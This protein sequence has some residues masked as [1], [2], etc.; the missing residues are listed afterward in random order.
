M[1]NLLFEIGLEEL[2]A[3]FI[4]DA[5][6]DLKIQLHQRLDQARLLN[7]NS[8]IT[9][10]GTARRLAVIATNIKKAQ[11]SIEESLEGPP[12]KIAKSDTGDWL[13][14]AIG[15]AKKCDV[16]ISQLTTRQN[17]KGQEVLF[18]SRRLEGQGATTLLPNIFSL[19]IQSMKCPIAMTWGNNIGP[20][21]RPIKWFC[22]MLD[23][24]II[25]FS[26]FNV[27]SSHLSYGHRF[28][29]NGDDASTGKAIVI[30]SPDEYPS[31]LAEHFVMVNPTERKSTIETQL[32]AL[33]SDPMINI[34]STLL[35]E[36]THLAEWPEVLQVEFPDSFLELPNEVLIECLKKHQK[37]FINT[38]N[39][40]L[41]NQ[42][43]IVA[44]SVTSDNR[45]NIIA[46]N[47]RVMLARLNDVQFFWDED[48]KNAGFSRWNNRLK[49]IIFQEGLGSIDEKVERI[50]H[51][52]HTIMD[53]LNVDASQ[54]DLVDRAAHRC[55]ADLV[56]HMVTE[57]PS[58]QGVM[59][60]YY[61]VVFKEELGVSVAIRDHYK[62]RFDGDTFPETLPGVIISIA[63]RIDTMVACFENNAIPTGSRDPWG[64][65]RSMI[66]IIRMVLNFNLDL[67]LKLLLEDAT[68]T[69]AKKIGENTLKCQ[70]FFEKRIE[71]VFSELGIPIDMIDFFGPRLF[72]QP[73]NAFKQAGLLVKLKTDQPAAFTQLL[74]TTARV[75]KIRNG[76]SSTMTVTINQFVEPIEHDV[77]QRLNEMKQQNQSAQLTED[78]LPSWLLFCQELGT[79]FENVLVNSEDAQLAHNR[80]GFIAL[81]NDYFAQVGHWEK[82]KK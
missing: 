74:E 4:D 60:G 30:S 39:H 24:S 32:K 48:L 2:P 3:R 41:T 80:Q 17:K 73:L 15:F 6:E 12:L 58:L 16:D 9:T 29:T 71:T 22:A 20:F 49:S 10:Y 43:C 7:D 27:Q 28:L 53:Q 25:P 68:L 54:R 63:D 35:N 57:L 19:V 69:L 67:N 21:M 38:K 14:P 5:L 23:D 44:D 45:K 46:G 56:S 42:C 50:C 65:R 18:L 72:E 26:H 79:Y 47:Q 82:I 13:P 59:G 61:A 66:A 40:E 76:A 31:Q 33:N 37:A 75:S 77:Y 8:S 51:L 64:I 70:Q 1:P 62:P 81:V 34:D 78:S 36:V 55:K 52:S 11:S